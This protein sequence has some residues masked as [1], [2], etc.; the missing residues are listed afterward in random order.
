VTEWPK[1]LPVLTA[2]Q[3]RIREDFYRVWLETLPRKYRLLE[4]FDHTYPARR[5][6]EGERTLEVGAGLGT[7]IRY[8]R[9]P[10]AEWAA[11][12]VRASMVEQLRREFPD[13]RAHVA[14][15]Q[16]ELPF[17]DHAFDRVLAVHVL[18]HMPNLPPALYEI[19]RV[20]RPEGRL[21]VLLPC[22]GGL[23]HRLARRVSARPLF[24]RRYGTS[25]DWFVAT[26]HCNLPHEVAHELRTLFRIEDITFF[27]LLLPSVNLNLVFG[28][29]LRPLP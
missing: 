16:A 18:E 1:R 22:E 26:E 15:C 21:V 24:E 23:M 9:V 25:Y 14:D 2:E 29:T 17:P 27:P 8:E 20:L 13:V 3:E 5:A 11:V 7:Q 28:M 19:R 12:D 10:Q 6:R 4:W